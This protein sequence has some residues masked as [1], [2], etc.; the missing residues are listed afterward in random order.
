VVSD[1]LAAEVV[2]RTLKQAG[3]VRHAGLVNC[4]G[5]RLPLIPTPLSGTVLIGRC[6]PSMLYLRTPVK[7]NLESEPPSRENFRSHCA[8]TLRKP[9]S[10]GVPHGA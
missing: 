3:N 7:E 5:K 2:E 8:T 9:R 6:I 4:V 1:A 10:A